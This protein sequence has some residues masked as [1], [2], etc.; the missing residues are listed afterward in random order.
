MKALMMIVLSVSV[1]NANAKTVE[2]V[3]Y[4]WGGSIL[5]EKDEKKFSR[6]CMAERDYVQIQTVGGV[7]SRKINKSIRDAMTVDRELKASD[8]PEKDS[9]E[10]LEY[11]NSASLSGQRNEKIGIYNVVHFPGGSGRYVVWCD[12]YEVRTARKIDLGACAYDD[13]ATMAHLSGLL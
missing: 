9:T 3:P 4:I 12:T 6:N 2:P 7:A 5:T 8:C 13:D 1:M 10:Y 11:K